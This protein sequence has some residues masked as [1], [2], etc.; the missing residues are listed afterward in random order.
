MNTIEKYFSLSGKIA[1]VTGGGGHLCSSMSNALCEAG[2]TVVVAD[3]RAKK[4]EAV[5]KQLRSKGF[6]AYSFAM[7]A[8]SKED[9]E[10]LRSF[11]ITKFERIDILINGA[12]TNSSTPFLDIELSEWNEVFNTQAVSTFLGCQTF[13]KEMVAQKSGSIINVSSASASPPLSNAYAYSAAKSSIVS[14][15]KNLA[16]EWAVSNVRVNAIRPGF[17]PTEWNKK[18][19]ITPQRESKILGHTP[20]GRYGKPEELNGAII[21]LSSP[22]ASFVTG[23][24]ITVDGGFSCMTI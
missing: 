22:S 2:A 8:S 6:N 5:E 3:L 17:F 18:N 24:E 16:R 20:F 14:I 11:V 10:E 9:W 1:I 19:F 15:T 4:A 7:D 23:A 21:W 13:G 12:G